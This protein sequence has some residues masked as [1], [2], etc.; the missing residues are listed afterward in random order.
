MERKEELLQKFGKQIAVFRKKKGFTVRELADAA[1]LEMA[2][3]QK[4]EAGKLNFRLST[5]VALAEG[6]G[7]SP[8]ELV[9]AL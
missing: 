2:Q 6:L 4:I 7:I 5:V 9:Q 1:G 3:V 8:S